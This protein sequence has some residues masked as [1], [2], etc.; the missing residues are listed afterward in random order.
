MDEPLLSVRQLTVD[1]VTDSGNFRAVD[2]LTFD[3]PKG[4]TVA[5]VGESGSGKSVTAQAILQI[6][7]KQATIGG[8]AIRFNDPATGTPVDIAGAWGR[9]RDHAR[10]ARR[11]HRHD[12]PGAD[13]IPVAAAH[14][15]RPDLGSAI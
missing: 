1:F 5:L 11:A 3:I 6:L 12:L 9:K 4:K 8:G 7:P 2:G 14:H 10:H 13:D 15:R